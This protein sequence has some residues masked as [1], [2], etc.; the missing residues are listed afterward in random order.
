MK[1]MVLGRY[2]KMC[3][4][5]YVIAREKWKVH[6]DLAK[7]FAVWK[8]TLYAAAKYGR[9]G[10]GKASANEQKAHVI[11]LEKDK[12]RTGILE[13]P[14]G[15]RIEYEFTPQSVILYFGKQKKQRITPDMYDRKVVIRFPDRRFYEEYV[16][17]A[18][19]MIKDKPIHY[20]RSK[21]YKDLWC[22]IRDLDWAQQLHIVVP[23]AM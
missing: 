23:E 6:E 1:M 19:E 20:F 13:T 12:K 22:K 8:A 4:L 15:D 5:W 2:P 9:F 17:F 7:A 10:V 3:V 16:L 18:L 21:W 14:F 11:N